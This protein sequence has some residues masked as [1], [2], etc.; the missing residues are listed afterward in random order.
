M[1]GD[2]NTGKCT[3]HYGQTV[4]ELKFQDVATITVKTETKVPGG[5]E[6]G[7]IRCT[8]VFRG[9]YVSTKGILLIFSSVELLLERASL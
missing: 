9:W 2:G 3:T 7:R 6:G 5:R 8:L 1:G 4:D